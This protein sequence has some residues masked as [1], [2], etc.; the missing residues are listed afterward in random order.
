MKMCEK[1]GYKI[2]EYPRE[3][4]RKIIYK[5]EKYTCLLHD[6]SYY[7][8]IEINGF[9]N[10]IKLLFNSI[11]DLAIPSITSDRYIKGNKMGNT[12]IY[13]FKKYPFNTISPIT[14]LWKPDKNNEID[15]RRTLWLWVHPSSCHD[16]LREIE[17]SKSVQKIDN[18]HINHM[19]DE[20][21]M[22][23]LAGPRSHAILQ[24]ILNLC[25]SINCNNNINEKAH[26]TWKSLKYLRT[27]AS[28]PAGVVLGL[29]VYDP[30]LSN[31]KKMKKR[32]DEISEE[33]QKL[34]NDICCLWP[35]NVSESDIWDSKLRD[36]LKNNKCSEN[37]L[38]KRRSESLVPGTTLEPLETDS[39][40]PILLIQRGATNYMISDNKQSQEL[41]YGWNL[42]IP[43]GWAMAFFKPL[44]FA[45][46]RV[47]GL[48]N[49]Y[50]LYFESNIPCYPYDYI[51]TKSY[52][53]YINKKAKE[54]E[55][56]FNRKPLSKRPNYQKL[57]IMSP[58]KPP[59]EAYLS[60]IKQQYQNNDDSSLWVLNTPKLINLFIEE[61]KI[62]SNTV[63]SLNK[64]IY[65]EII[66]Y[67]NKHEIFIS[68]DEIKKNNTIIN[69]FIR[70]SVDILGKGVINDNSIIYLSTKTEYDKW[71]N[72]KK[73]EKNNTSVYN[74]G[75]F[76][77]PSSIIGFV[78]TGHYS[79]NNA[80]AKAIGCCSVIGVLNMMHNNIKN[81]YKHSTFILVR[82]PKGQVIRPAIINFLS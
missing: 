16:L 61:A 4:G 33:N 78:T 75:E 80:H 32:E 18:V 77:S 19:N 74:I 48:K 71:L 79:L 21:V 39:K 81:N 12:K 42:L 3:K 57:G 2:A 46:A 14:F 47:I 72:S 29:T 45:G 70:V 15:N 26:K 38:N 11:T 41:L 76:P 6:A 65:S 64:K 54:E 35:E 73:K 43:K 67:Y 31:F 5:D 52:K 62:K 53:N 27:P 59:F 17:I 22:F 60:M 55:E 40:I 23:Q 20:I 66:D 49:I 25:D 37:L 1:W 69:A 44:V 50:E 82:D 13:E 51:E 36:Q 28:L 24:E 63:D 34:I 8:C 7:Q 68:I 30:R 58:F 10:D 56:I 9:V